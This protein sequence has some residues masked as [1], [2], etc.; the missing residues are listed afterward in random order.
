MTQ[1]RCKT[2]HCS[3]SH[4]ADMMTEEQK[5]QS[6]NAKR[7]FTLS[8]SHYQWIVYLWDLTRTIKSTRQQHGKQCLPVPA[9]KSIAAPASTEQQIKAE[10]LCMLLKKTIGGKKAEG[11]QQLSYSISGLDDW[12]QNVFQQNRTVGWPLVNKH[13]SNADGDGWLLT[14]WCRG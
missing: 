10:V 13:S 14:H 12:T 3:T 8:V 1:T 11:A 6:E 9:Q 7:I 5:H 4:A 2:N